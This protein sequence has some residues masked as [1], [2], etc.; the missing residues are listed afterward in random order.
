M[1]LDTVAV[2]HAVLAEEPGFCM[3]FQLFSLVITLICGGGVG[4]CLFA[5]PCF[6]ATVRLG[7]K[8]AASTLA[9]RLCPVSVASLEW[10]HF[11]QPVVRLMKPLLWS[12]VLRPP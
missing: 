7:V 10:F 2:A 12:R 9:S 3:L 6:A 4:C 5:D 11:S 8:P 1:Y